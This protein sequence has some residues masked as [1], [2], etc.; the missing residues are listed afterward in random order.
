[1]SGTIFGTGSAV[2]PKLLSFF[3]KPR[4]E[5]ST[6]TSSDS[7]Q[8][9]AIVRSLKERALA[10]RVIEAGRGGF[11]QAIVGESHYQNVLQRLK[12]D[13]FI[14]LGDTPIA[15]FLIAR[16][17]DNPHDHGAIAVLTD[18]GDVVGY[19]SREDAQRLQPTL[20]EHEERDEVLSCSGKLVG[21]DIIGV[22]LD[23]PHLSEPRSEHQRPVESLPAYEN[24]DVCRDVANVAALIDGHKP[25]GRSRPNCVGNRIAAI[26]EERYASNLERVSKGRCEKGERITLKV[27]LVPDVN[28]PIDPVAVMITTLR[29][30][31]LGYLSKA[32]AERW[33]RGIRGFFES[34]RVVSRE[35]GLHQKTFKSGKRTFYLAV[36]MTDEEWL[37]QAGCRDRH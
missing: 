6:P 34:A 27:L 10:M 17:P 32:H 35:A 20:L 25:Y 2:I 14:A 11:V 15:T 36:E 26:G 1:V 31:V 21:D 8:G 4:A 29:G 7:K 18:G 22:W 3:L 16:E 13:A 12:R 5:L 19:L 9:A 30:D 33:G 24:L 28:N 37:E 23:L